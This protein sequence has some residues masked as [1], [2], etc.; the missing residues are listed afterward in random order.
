MSA[1]DHLKRCAHDADMVMLR[2]LYL[3]WLN[4]QRETPMQKACGI[5]HFGVPK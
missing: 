1:A 4:A 2:A 3:S 5:L